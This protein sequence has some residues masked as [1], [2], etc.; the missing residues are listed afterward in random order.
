MLVYFNS[1]FCNY[2][3][4]LFPIAERPIW[5]FQCNLDGGL[6]P[7]LP[8]QAS[9]AKK[10][11]DERPT[12]NIQHPTPN[13]TAFEQRRLWVFPPGHEHGWQVKDKVERL[14]FHFTAVPGE[15][16][17][18]IPETGYYQVELSDED[19]EQMRRLGQR[20]EEMGS[21]PTRLLFLQTQILVG[22]LSL[23][24]LRDIAHPALPQK[25]IAD[26]KTERALAFYR[27]HMAQD[28]SFEDIAAAVGICPTHLRRLFHKARGERPHQVFNRLRM[29]KAEQLL[30]ETDDL[31]N[32]IA[33]QVG[34]SDSSALSRAVKTHFGKTPSELRKERGPLRVH[35][36][37]PG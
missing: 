16:E 24:A 23:M 7:I 13:E 33:G 26:N 8:G 4:N 14:V 31:L 21:H 2:R 32:V 15:L 37:M 19:C 6:A 9:G 27:E 22:E 28:P 12:S 35:Q 11:K 18:Q 25:Q 5:E 1:G 10:T 29:E 34:F 20:A 17:N 36:G 3:N 30:R